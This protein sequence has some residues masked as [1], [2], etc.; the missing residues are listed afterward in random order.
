MAKFLPL[1]L[2]LL[3]HA[4][5]RE[6]LGASAIIE[7]F[8]QNRS[9]E[10]DEPVIDAALHARTVNSP[11]T[12]KAAARFFTAA[13]WARTLLLLAGADPNLRAKDGRTAA[14]RAVSRSLDVAYPIML[15]LLALAH[16]DVNAHDNA[17]F[18][19][20]SRG[21]R[22]RITVPAVKLRAA[23]RRRP[24]A[25]RCAWQPDAAVSRS[26]VL[27]AGQQN[28]G[29]VAPGRRRTFHGPRPAAGTRRRAHPPRRWPPLPASA[30]LA[31]ISDALASGA[32]INARDKDGATA[33]Y[34]AVSDRQASTAALLLLNGANPNLAKNDG[35]T[36]LM[37][38]AKHFEMASERML[39]D[40]I[41]AGADVNATAKDGTTA[42][43]EAVHS[44]N[45]TAAQ[46]MIWRGADLDVHAPDGTLMQIATV[47][48]DW[49]SMIALLKKAGLPDQ[50]LARRQ[51]EK[52][53]PSSTPCGPATSPPWTPN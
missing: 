2:V 6:A 48:P 23:P 12:R 40:L 29:R 10:E 38:C 36:P 53:H 33:L 32:D 7:Q 50:E 52:F 4:V 19:R 16:T 47:H 24:R 45:N 8:K 13:T 51:G 34:R 39:M 14:F 28:G 1:L 17:G 20:C 46:W 3:L 22:T 44:C 18:P 43:S 41:V 15:D 49:P 5:A 31:T 35:R 30:R 21:P 27:H 9:I 42:L 37:E 25:Q 11:W 26:W